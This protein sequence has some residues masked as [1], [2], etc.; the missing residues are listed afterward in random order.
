MIRRE[1]PHEAQNAS[2][3][4]AG[5]PV[6][7]APA[8]TSRLAD[9]RQRR[10]REGNR[11]MRYT[12]GAGVRPF[13]KRSVPTK[14]AHQALPSALGVEPAPPPIPVPRP[15]VLEEPRTPRLRGQEDARHPAEDGQPM[16]SNVFEARTMVDSESVLRHRF[17]PRDDVY[18]GIDQLVY[19]TE[20][21]DPKSVAPDVFVS[22][23]VPSYMRDIYRIAEEGKPP[24]WVIEIA[25]RATYT[26][27]VDEKKDLYEAMG[28]GEYWVY[29]PKGD[30]HDPRLRAWVLGPGGYEEL[31]DLK[32]PGLE[33]ALRSEALGLE[34]HFDGTDLRMWDPVERAYL[35]TLDLAIEE[36]DEE[37]RARLAAEAKAETAEAKAKAAEAERDAEKRARLAVE[38]ELRRLRS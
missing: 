25:S 29:D 1:L 37:R 17:N 24:D 4:P 15:K 20:G 10:G 30:M 9:A 23:D 11:R 38:A 7:S 12:P 8:G 5:P 19:Y 16:A 6:A 26:K 18:V 28:V 32:R 22:F 13:R 31:A 35:P 33:V 21:E 27:D 14:K 36:R 34:F 2:G 3:P